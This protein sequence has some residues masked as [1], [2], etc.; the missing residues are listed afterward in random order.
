MKK[1]AAKNYF[2]KYDKLSQE[3]G[4]DIKKTKLKLSD[5]DKEEIIIGLKEVEDIFE[6]ILDS[7]K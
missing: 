4:A 5:E 7:V 6:R 1:G 3:L 2:E